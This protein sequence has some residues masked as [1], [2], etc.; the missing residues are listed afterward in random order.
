MAEHW[1]PP[2]LSLQECGLR[3]WDRQGSDL[4]KFSNIV[5]SELLQRDY[6][7][8]VVMLGDT[9]TNSRETMRQILVNTGMADRLCREAGGSPRLVLGFNVHKAFPDELAS[10]RGEQEELEAARRQAAQAAGA[11][12]AGPAAAAA[13]AA[14]TGAA[15]LAATPFSQMYSEA[16]DFSQ[17]YESCDSDDGD[18]VTQREQLPDDPVSRLQRE[19]DESR[20]MLLGNLEG[21][22]QRSR[23][24]LV[25]L[26]V[27]D[28][29]ALRHLPEGERKR[30]AE[31][32]AAKVVYLPMY[33]TDENLLGIG[34]W[35]PKVMATV[36]EQAELKKQ[37]RPAGVAERKRAELHLQEASRLMTQNAAQCQ[38]AITGRAGDPASTGG[39]ALSSAAA[40]LHQLESQRLAQHSPQLLGQL[41]CSVQSTCGNALTN[42]LHTTGS[43]LPL[44][45]QALR[46][47]TTKLA[48]PHFDTRP[49]VEAL[50]Q[51]PPDMAK[52]QRQLA[53][54]QQVYLINRRDQKVVAELRYGTVVDTY[55]NGN[56]LHELCYPHLFHGSAVLAGVGLAEVQRPLKDLHGL[57][58]PQLLQRVQQNGEWCASGKSLRW[59]LLGCGCAWACAYQQ[60]SFQCPHVRVLHRR[61]NA[62]Y[63]PAHCAMS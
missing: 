15:A 63:L 50:S 14:A 25:Q 62:T 8:L 33:T 22:Q 45:A 4:G 35:V 37:Q 42:L 16:Y 31:L 28:T 54:F 52:V 48:G 6:L 58:G 59:L 20:R 17:T 1:L 5:A 3:V 61:Y 7:T 21:W 57:Q 47:V 40:H 19:V 60:R 27:E 32:I 23:K 38:A 53:G 18:E 9:R 44:V 12:A 13:A 39:G 26:L 34:N 11:Q 10:L 36:K 56:L 51:V 41:C 46:D 55:G 30:R 24:A 43:D 29:E 2:P 49:L